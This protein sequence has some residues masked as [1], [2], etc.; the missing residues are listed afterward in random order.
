MNVSN[1]NLPSLASKRPF[2]NV[3]QAVTLAEKLFHFKHCD[4]SAAKEFD[5]YDD[6]NFHLNGTLG[7]TDQACQEFIFKVLNYVDSTNAHL[8]DAYMAFMLFTKKEG[9]S[10]P[11]PVKSAYNDKYYVT[12]KLPWKSSIKTAVE[13]DEGSNRPCQQNLTDGIEIYEGRSCLKENEC[14]CAIWMVKFVPGKSLHEV[15]C[16]ARLL[17]ECGQFLARLHRRLKVRLH[18]LHCSLTVRFHLLHRSLKVRLHRLHR[19]LKVRL[20][21]LLCSLKTA[22]TAS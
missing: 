1:D 21:L 6:R 9:F 14:I 17:N 3:Q 7:K 12:C 5:S 20:L 13:L 10:C 2:L 18:P 22:S 16:T 4:R 8:V 19:S 15:P 11:A